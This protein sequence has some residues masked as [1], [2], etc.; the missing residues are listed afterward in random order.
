[1]IVRH[2]LCLAGIFAALAGLACAQ[3]QPPPTGKIP[4]FTPVEK[5]F[6]EEL[7]DVADVAGLPRV[8]L[9]GDSIS[10]GYTLAVRSRLAGR[11]NVHRPPENC[12]STSYGL[13]RLA[14]WLKSGPW[15]VIHFNFGLHDLKYLDAQ[16]RYVSPE[17][18]GK[19]VAS[20]EEYGANLRQ[21]VQL[22]KPTGARLIFATTTPV[23]AGA[24]GRIAGSELEYNRVA[25]KIM[26][27]AGIEI[28]DLHAYATPRSATIQLPHNVHFTPAGSDE[29]GAVVADKIRT[30]LPSPPSSP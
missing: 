30:V 2:Q 25:L 10:I 8:L 21:L 7:K 18:G 11:A 12:G 20:L 14:L 26:R 17:Q 6:Q 4:G 9:I 19:Q 29:L 13:T 22:L 23:P 5:A 1:M 27:E 28:D 16:G 15:D 3:D 24:T